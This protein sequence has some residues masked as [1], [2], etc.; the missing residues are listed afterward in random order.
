MGPWHV[1][2][3]IHRARVVVD[4]DK[5]LV[6]AGHIGIRFCIGTEVHGSRMFRP[7]SYNV[8]VMLAGA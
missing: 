6:D 3:Q 1:G 7:N 4:E 5:I 8:G 2:A